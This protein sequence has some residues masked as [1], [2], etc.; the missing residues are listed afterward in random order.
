MGGLALKHL[1]I[2]RLNHN[3]YYPLIQEVQETFKKLFKE[4]AYLIPSYKDKIDF[5]D[6]DMIVCHEKLPQD[7]RTIIS[8]Y[9]SSKGMNRNGEVTSIE[10]NR[11]QFDFISIETK[12]LV[13][14]LMYFSYNDLGNLI[15]RIAH[16][17]GFK[18]GQYGLRYVLR[19]KDHVIAEISVSI[20]PE[21]YFP[22]L[23]YN[24]S[25]FTQGFQT[26]E[27][28]FIYAAST[29]YFNP[30]IYLLDNRNAISRVRDA[31]RKTYTDFLKWCNK[32]QSNLNI[33]QWEEVQKQ[34][35]LKEAI[36]KWI[37]FGLDLAEEKKLL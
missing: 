31:K 1:D 8:E 2:K 32:H 36:E 18:L 22:F 14:A 7:W 17:M 26:L 13:T 25:R 20:N 29:P 4:P 30:E 27:D 19:E 35:F 24:Y 23:G 3:E 12:Y 16:K 28:I 33:Y 9:Y 37:R 10:I 21:E 11:F 5:G 15:G 34:S 6:C